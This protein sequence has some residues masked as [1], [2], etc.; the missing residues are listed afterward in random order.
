MARITQG[1]SMRDVPDY[2]VDVQSEEPV[3]DVDK[4][5]RSLKGKKGNLNPADP[6]HSDYINQILTSVSSGLASKTSVDILA[7]NNPTLAPMLYKAF[8]TFDREKKG[9]QEVQG[10]VSKYINPGSPAVQA[11]PAKPEVPFE[12]NEEQA[13]GLPGLRGNVSQMAQAEVPG[14]PEIPAVRNYQGAVDAL[15]PKYPDVAEKYQKLGGLDKKGSLG[16]LTIP[17][18]LGGSH[19]IKDMN[20]VIRLADTPEGRKKLKEFVKDYQAYQPVTTTDEFGN[21]RTTYS[22]KLDSKGGS[23]DSTLNKRVSDLWG[24][25]E[26]SRITAVAPAFKVLDKKMDE[27]DTTGKIEGIGNLKNI[28]ASDWVKTPEGKYMSSVIQLLE[29]EEL[30]QASGLAVTE[31]EAERKERADALKAAN[32]AADYAKIYKTMIRPRWNNLVSGLKASSGNDAL[33]VL[34]KRGFDIDK[35]MAQETTKPANKDDRKARED[36]AIRAL[37]GGQ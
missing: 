26:K 5:Y 3:S 22:P 7:E 10:I 2:G 24:L 13:F 9:Q 20:D 25:V 35:L 32:T 6:K 34:K 12:T 33:D 31:P 30:R 16:E 15:A 1:A 36:A 29:N 19:G 27:Y 8:D 23:A 17:K 11:V 4:Y 14:S 37:R 21:V 28:K 18:A